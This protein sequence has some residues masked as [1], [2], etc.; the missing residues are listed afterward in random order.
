MWLCVDIDDSF[1]SGP[2]IR[3][4][5]RFRL[6]NGEPGST[7]EELDRILQ[8]S[9]RLLQ[10][11]RERSGAGGG[12]EMESGTEFLPAERGD[13]QSCGRRIQ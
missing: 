7:D 13:V 1:D 3:N 6:A 11:L 9:V 4:E 8:R 10:K 5:I 12:E 2:F